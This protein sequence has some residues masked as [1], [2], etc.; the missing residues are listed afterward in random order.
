MGHT[1]PPGPSTLSTT[2]RERAELLANFGDP[3]CARIWQLAAAELDEVLQALG[4][5]TLTLAEAA[6]ESGYSQ[7]HLGS[8]IRGG[9]LPNAGRL[10]T[11]LIRRRDLPIKS[12]TSP[13]RPAQPPRRKAA[14]G[15]G[16]DG[17][18]TSIT[19]KLSPRR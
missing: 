18:I 14:I 5:E 2:W 4:A 10:H 6:R 8:L 16:D 15:G 11:P 19:N 17:D 9:K 3:N 1:Y 7:D 13:G 12:S